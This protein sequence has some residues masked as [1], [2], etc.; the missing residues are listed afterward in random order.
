MS[1]IVTFKKFPDVV[2]TREL[3]EFLLKNNIECY[4]ADNKAFLN[5]FTMF[6]IGIIVKAISFLF[7]FNL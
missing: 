2:Q 5:G 4:L 7:R 6:C 3:K 1:E